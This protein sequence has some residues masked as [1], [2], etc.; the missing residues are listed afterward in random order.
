M[1]FLSHL[2]SNQQHASAL[3]KHVFDIHQCTNKNMIW[4]SA[5][6]A[7]EKEAIINSLGVIFA[8]S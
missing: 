7:K 1:L 3:L 2:H 4:Q 6:G 5:T 8:C